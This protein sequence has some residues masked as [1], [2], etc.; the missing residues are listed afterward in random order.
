MAN[1]PKIWRIY[2]IMITKQLSVVLIWLM[3]LTACV[4]FA[5]AQTNDNA[6]QIKAQVLKRGTNETKRVVVKTVDGRSF[7]G[8]ISRI[9]SDT[10]DLTNSKTKQISTFTYRDVSQVKKSGGLSTGSIIAIAGGAAAAIVVGVIVGT[11]CRNE[12]G[13]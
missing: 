10:F 8:Y 13:C 12:G 1:L 3:L 9:D 7:K 5:S 11:Y 4:P 2:K 6:A